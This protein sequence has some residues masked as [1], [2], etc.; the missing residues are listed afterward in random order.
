M[1]FSPYAQ[2]L[3]YQ[4]FNFEICIEEYIQNIWP[5]KHD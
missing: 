1:D 4:Q 2:E 5:R 3:I